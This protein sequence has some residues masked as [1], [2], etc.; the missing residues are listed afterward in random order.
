MQA[1]K[2]TNN[3]ESKQS[4]NQ[5]RSRTMND[6]H[7]ENEEPFD[8]TSEDSTLEDQMSAH[9]AAIAASGVAAEAEALAN[10]QADMAAKERRETRLA[11]LAAVTVIA[12]LMAYVITRIVK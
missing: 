8:G 9:I 3:Q 11:L 12:G 2:Q 5:E 4:N 6:N 7:N 1:I 10:R